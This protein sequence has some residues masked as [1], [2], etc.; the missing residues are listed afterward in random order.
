MEIVWPWITWYTVTAYLI[1]SFVGW[2]LLNAPEYGLNS[3]Q[4]GRG[5]W[6][7]FECLWE[8]LLENIPGGLNRKVAKLKEMVGPPSSRHSG[9]FIGSRK[10]WTHEELHTTGNWEECARS[11]FGGTWYFW[12]VNVCLY[13]FVGPVVAVFVL[14]SSIIAVSLAMLKEAILRLQQPLR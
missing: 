6:W 5:R 8:E 12:S 9:C 3:G 11:V 13:F 4:L 14:P 1:L 2:F 10:T 7:V